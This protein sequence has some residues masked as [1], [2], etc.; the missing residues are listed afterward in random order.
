MRLLGIDPA[1]RVTGYGVID[2][3]GARCTL[4]EAGVVKPKPGALETRLNQ[5]HAAMVDIIV[6]TR[7]DAVVIEELYTSYKSP[8][9]AILMG[10]ARGVLALASA[11]AGVPV[12]TIGHAHVKRSLVGS[13]TARKEQV[14]AMVAQML[15]LRARPRPLDVSDALALAL[16]FHHRTARGVALRAA[17]RGR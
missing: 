5:L 3:N 13:G 11:Q 9:T 16:A 2:A 15:G 4:V 10:H 8:A 1:L 12:H 17:K 7:P 6:Q 14:A